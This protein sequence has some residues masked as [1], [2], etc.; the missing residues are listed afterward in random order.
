MKD[1]GSGI[2]FDLLL[3]GGEVKNSSNRTYVYSEV[4]GHHL[5]IGMKL[6]PIETGLPREKAIHTLTLQWAAGLVV[7]NPPTIFIENLSING[8][9][10]DFICG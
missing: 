2:Q 4:V 5:S 10:A 1:S 3:Q 8:A 7:D 6:R 9:S